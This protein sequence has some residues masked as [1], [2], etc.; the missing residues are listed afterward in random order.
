MDTV[1]LLCITG[2]NDDNYVFIP[3]Q[4]E[5]AGVLNGAEIVMEN[6]IEK[7]QEFR[8]LLPFYTRH[9]KAALTL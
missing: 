1:Y 7:A 5:S 6:V 4:E 3:T 9:T 2:G 8:I